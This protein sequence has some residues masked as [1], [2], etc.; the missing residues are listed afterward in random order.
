MDLQRPRTTFTVAKQELA[1]QEDERVLLVQ[2]LNKEFQTAPEKLELAIVE[3]R[4]RSAD[5]VAAYNS[6]AS[7]KL[8]GASAEMNLDARKAELSALHAVLLKLQQEQ[9][10]LGPQL[11]ANKLQLEALRKSIDQT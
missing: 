5:K 3:A 7:L 11:A 2:K 9:A 10:E 1:K 4:T 8:Q 6:Q